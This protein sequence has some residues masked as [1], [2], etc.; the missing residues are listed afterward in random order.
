MGKK[1]PRKN[2]SG[3]Y[4]INPALDP[5]ILFDD[6]DQSTPLDRESVGGSSRSAAAG[7]LR[8][9]A[10]GSGYG[11]AAGSASDSGEGLSGVAESSRGRSMTRSS[12]HRRSEASLSV[13]REERSP[14]RPA[15]MSEEGGHRNESRSRALIP[16][17]SG[18][19]KGKGKAIQPA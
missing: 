19:D 5:E 17:G 9:I 6:E 3:D 8:S 16:E 11:N 13:I 18:Q 12:S 4:E 2:T 7:R 10:R 14:N 15:R 1:I